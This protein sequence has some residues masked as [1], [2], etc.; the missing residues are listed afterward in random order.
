MPEFMEILL[1]YKASLLIQI[2]FS[3]HMLQQH[4]YLLTKTPDLREV[5]SDPINYRQTCVYIRRSPFHSPIYI[6]ATTKDILQRKHSRSRKFQQRLRSQT[7]YVE[8]A[9]HD[10]HQPGGQLW[11]AESTW[12]HTLRPQLNAPWVPRLLARSAAC[13]TIT[14][15]TDP[16]QTV[17]SPTTSSC[18]STFPSGM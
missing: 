1:C 17:Q 14:K 15:I 6:G 12:Q 3:S 18:T 13:A 5:A 7:A 10:W 2:L 9:F 16:V 8:P 11:A 4:A